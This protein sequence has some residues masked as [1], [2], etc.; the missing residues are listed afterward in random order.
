MAGKSN[1]AG[2]SEVGS[3]HS[4]NPFWALKR[5]Q[6][7]PFQLLCATFKYRH[8]P[9]LFYNAVSGFFRLQHV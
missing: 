3:N 5:L 8:L 9:T 1:K 7:L 4:L 2:L 6:F